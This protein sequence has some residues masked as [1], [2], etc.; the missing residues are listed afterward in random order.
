[1]IISHLRRIGLKEL[2]VLKVEK[3]WAWGKRTSRMG[4]N[5][6]LG[7]QDVEKIGPYKRRPAKKENRENINGKNG[8]FMEGLAKR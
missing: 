3:N 6:F 2:K 4:A 5:S 1:M 8:L 7:R